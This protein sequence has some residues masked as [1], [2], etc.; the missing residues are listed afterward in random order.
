MTFACAA[1]LAVMAGPG[2]ADLPSE[3]DV[4]ALH[5]ALMACNRAAA[6]GKLSQG[7][8]VA[9]SE[10]YLELK[11]AFV[12]SVDRALYESMSPDER[13]AVALLGY[14]L[15]QCWRSEGRCGLELTAA[16]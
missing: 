14:Q 1:G 16:D 11:L 15:L 6:E 13:A 2:R 9:C 12:P 7:E 3:R 10:V 5:D 4:Q 8:V